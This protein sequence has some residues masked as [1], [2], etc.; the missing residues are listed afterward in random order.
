MKK[1]TVL[2]MCVLCAFIAQAQKTFTLSSPDGKLQ[3][4]ITTGDKLTYDITCNGRQIL[5]ASPISMTLDNGEVWGEKAKLSGTSRKSVDRMIPS[6]FYRA[7]ELRDY[8]NELTL[9]FKKDWNVEFRAYD[10]GIVY[11]FTNRSKKPFKVVDEEVDY[12]FPNDM[13]ATVP[14]VRTGKDGDFNSQFYNSFENTYTTDKLSKLNKQR[15]MFLPLV[16]DAGEGVKL[17]ITESDLENYPGL[18]LSV[19]EVENSLKGIFAPYPKRA[20]QGGHNKLQMLVKEREAYIAKVDTPR[21]FPWRMA[22]VTTADKDLAASN[23]SYLLAAP[24]RLSD[25]SWIKPGKVAWDWWNDWNLDGVDFVTGVNN[26]TYKAY[27][28]FAAS[29][30]I[31]YVILDEGWAVNL[32]ADLMQ[33]VKEIDLKELVDYAASKNVGIILWVGY[34]AFERDMENVCRHYAA[35]GVKGF[36][37]DFMDRDDQE[38]TAFNYRAAEMCAKYK[39]ILDLHGTHKPAGLN[40]TYPNV[41]N[42]EG[43]NGLEQ[44]KW[45]PASLDQVKYDVMIP[46]IRQVSGPMDYTQGAMRNASKGNYYPCNSEPMSQGTRCRQLALYVVFES[47]FNMLC[48]N[49]GNYMR[50]PESTD[51]IAGIPTVWDE[52]IVLDGKMGEYIVTA[53]R[54]GNVWYV[55]GITDWTARDIEVDCSFLG[56][57][58]THNA[59]LFKDGVNAHRVGRDYKRESLSIKKNNKLKIHLAPGGGFALQIK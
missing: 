1:L 11:R 18:Y 56:D 22:I 39:L 41:L 59:T 40:R 47:P 48:D 13:T 8:Y 34:Y 53:R 57:D 2:L 3:T 52:S 45:S 49:P 42:F 28:D 26:A 7:N 44:M 51:F 25:I 55:G 37:V 20:E 6:P 36:K 31:E 29:K 9:R 46:F 33:V 5:A 17:C 16:V 21:S 15:L 58:K 4:T 27:I 38:M 24:S 43:V 10:D 19:A 30:G 32:K 50:E 23:L 35:M 14:Y 54:S 12:R